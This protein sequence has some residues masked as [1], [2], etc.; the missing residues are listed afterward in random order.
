MSNDE[1]LKH[2]GAFL[3]AAMSGPLCTPP[4]EGGPFTPKPND[5]YLIPSA[6]KYADQ[7]LAQLLEREAEQKAKAK[8]ELQ[9][10]LWHASTVRVDLPEVRGG[11]R[12]WLE[13]A[14]GDEAEAKRIGRLMVKRHALVSSVYKR[15]PPD[16]Q[17]EFGQ[18]SDEINETSL[19]YV[20]HQEGQ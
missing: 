3:A 18:L 1:Q 8:R 5:D 16:D 13:V 2:W 10:K 12:G 4:R 19:R 6:A 15:P 9:K 14:P 11:L 20:F 17:W 7:A